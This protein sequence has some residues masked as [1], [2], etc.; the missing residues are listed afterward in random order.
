MPGIPS[1]ST[2]VSFNF[3][4]CTLP[5]GGDAP[6][7]SNG[8]WRCLLQVTL[9]HLCSG[10]WLH[11]GEGLA[12]TI[13]RTD[14]AAGH[15]A[16]DCPLSVVAARAI[17]VVLQMNRLDLRQEK[18]LEVS[19]STWCLVAPWYRVE[20]APRK[21]QSL[22]SRAYAIRPPRTGQLWHLS[23]PASCISSPVRRS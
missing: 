7:V 5:P 6:A 2:N 4:C 22:T 15:G 23:P 20:Q 16:E 9:P 19:P 1:P 3:L 14:C 8:G 21:V 12:G 13:G 18:A 17:R 11:K 10:R